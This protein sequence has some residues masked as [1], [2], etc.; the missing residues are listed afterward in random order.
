MYRVTIPPTDLVDSDTQSNDSKIA[1]QQEQSQSHRTDLVNSAPSPVTVIRNAPPS[2][3]TIPPYW[4]GQFRL[5]DG[6]VTWG[7]DWEAWSQSHR[8]DLVKGQFRRT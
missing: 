6:H 2:E 4:P 1:Q 5:E 8:T 7:Y 3:V